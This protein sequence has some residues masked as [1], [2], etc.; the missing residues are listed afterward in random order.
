M[1]WK[2]P[3]TVIQTNL[4]IRDA[5]KIVPARLARQVRDMGADAWIFNVGGIYAWYPTSVPHH[6]QGAFVEDYPTL[7][8]EVIAACHQEGMKF[9]ARFDFG[10]AVDEIYN[11]HPEWFVQLLDRR[12]PVFGPHRPGGW[13]LLHPTCIR[14]G[15]RNEAVGIPVLQEALT[16]YAIDGV[17]INGPAPRDCWCETCRRAYQES[18]GVPMPDAGAEFHPL[19][20]TLQYKYSVDR[21]H[22]AIQEVNPDIP[23]VL[24]YMYQ[25]ITGEC[26]NAEII[27]EEARDSLSEGVSAAWQPLVRMQFCQA[28]SKEAPP[29][30]FIH[31]APGL[32]WRHVGL[33][34]AEYR[35]WL[36]QIPASGATLIHSL[37]GI[38]DTFL[39]KRVFQSVRWVNER[40]RQVYPLI[41]GKQQVAEVAVL[42]NEAHMNLEETNSFPWANALMD[43]QVPFTPLLDQDVRRQKLSQYR[44]VVAP[45]GYVY[46]PESLLEVEAYVKA[47]GNLLQEGYLCE[48]DELLYDMCGLQRFGKRGPYLDGAYFRSE[49]A[50]SLLNAGGLEDSVFL[51]LRGEV[52][53]A[54][55]TTAETLATLVPPYV[56][57]CEAFT[58]PER[59]SMLT[60]HTDI[61]ICTQ[62]RYGQGRVAAL[63]LNLAGLYEEYRLADHLTVLKNLVVH[64]SG[65][66]LLQLPM[67]QGLYATLFADDASLVLHLTNGTGRRPLANATPL[68]DLAVCLQTGPVRRVE[69]VFH[70]REIPFRCDTQGCH[71]QVDTLEI[72]NCYHIELGAPKP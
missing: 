7:L 25:H 48:K 30:G 72:W 22:G 19:W 41:K 40:T 71:F 65:G 13:E 58:P 60:D 23:L 26:L 3:I 49:P 45:F 68:H 59:A 20:R 12:T 57:A 55:T 31:S 42:V 2:D 11:H 67:L 64:M 61:P 63:T 10:T 39:D 18:F 36:S 21:M 53:Y 34:P 51:A 32:D 69:D 38:P 5:L 6:H 27:C 28:F 35:F 37:T 8:D 70:Q 62:N 1:W 16:R 56:P 9:I 47:G 46:T 66:L 54:R 14:S 15:Y 33:P 4:Q 44:L 24:Y 29:W 17:F 43:M 50:G 52:F